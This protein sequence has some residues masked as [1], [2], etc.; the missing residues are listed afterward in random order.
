MKSNL[1]SRSSSLR[2]PG[3][4]LIAALLSLLSA[5]ASVPDSQQRCDN[6]QHTQNDPF[7]A[8]N[9]GVFAFDLALDRT[10]IK[11]VAKAYRAALPNVVRDSIRSVIDNLKEPLVFINNVL[12]GRA[13]AAGITARRFL[14]NTTIGVAGLNDR[15]VNFGLPRQTGDFGQTLFVWGVSD[16]PYLVLPFFGPS[17][18]RDTFGLG[19]DLYASP[20]GRVGSSD[21]RRDAAISVGVADGVDLRARNIETLEELEASS[22]DFYAYLRSVTRQQRHAV[23]QVAT[24]DE[25]APSLGDELVDPGDAPAPV[26][27]ATGQ[28]LDPGPQSRAVDPCGAPAMQWPTR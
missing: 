1:R 10:V 12:Q 15:A 24:L 11:P 6:V 5:C 27:P 21:V 25:S 7:E 26:L 3:L 23:L 17:N 16:G 28:A 22:L 9:R 2:W 8:F 18:V 14:I 4:A 19:V 20:L 13:T